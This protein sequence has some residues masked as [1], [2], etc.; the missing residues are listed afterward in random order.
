M[1]TTKRTF[2]NDEFKEEKKILLSITFSRAL[3]QIS[4]LSPFRTPAKCSELIEQEVCQEM[5]V[6][7]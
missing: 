5:E 2:G 4:P 1:A 3:F 6:K 7:N